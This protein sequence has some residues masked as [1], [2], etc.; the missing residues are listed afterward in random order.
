MRVVVAVLFL[1]T[2]AHAGL[3]GLLR[4]KQQAA[5]FTGIL[6]SVS[7]APFDG[8]G[9]PDVDNF[10]TAERIRSDL[11]KLA[12]QTRAV[13]LYSSTGGPEM[14][15]PI[16]NEFGLK[17]NVGAWIDKDV[18]RNEREIQAAIDLAKHN[19]NVSGIVV[20][21]ET[22]YR[23][24][25]IPLE[26]LG[27]SDEERYRLVAEENQ[28]MRDAEAQP[29]DKRDE[30]VRWATA[31][32]NVRRLTRLI[33]RVKS[34]VKAPVTSGEI[35]NIWL[36]HPE[37]AS[38]VDFIAAHILPYWEGFSAKQAVDQA[39]IIYQ[40]L[41]DAFPGKRIVIAEFGWPS[42]GY[43]R[44]A[45]VPG[46]FEQAVTLRNFVS[47]ADAVGM[48][49][50]I[51]EAIDQPWKFFEG[52]VGPYW[53]F[54][55]ASRQ[56][57]FAWTGPVVDPNYWKLAGI[58]LLV[59]I[60]LSLPILQLAA[61]TAM[62]TLL[63]SA[64]AHGAGAWAATVFAYWNGHY[65]L[66]GSAFALTLGMILLVPLVAI[67]LARV[68]EIAA[69][70]FGRK[71]RRLITR[72][73]TDAQEAKR[74]A[75]LASGEPIKAPK[76]SIH[77]P[78]YFE[79]PEM[80]KQTLDALARLDY[81]NFEVVVIINNTPDAA[82]TDP[83]R[84]HC[85][86]LGERFKFINAQKVKGFKAGALRI[87][88]ERTAADAEII[89]IIDAD[90]VV[91]PDW[92]KDLVPAFD[93][94]RVGLVQA[95]QEHRDGDR[96]L[97]HYIMNG[98][99]AGFFDIG[100]VQRNEYNGIIVHGTM[101]LIRRAAMDMAGGWSSDTICEDSDLG[102]EIM[103]HGWLTHYTNTR[104]GFG[105]LP[106]TYEAF[107]KQR[108]R[109]AYGGFQIIKKHWRRF[110][111]GNSRLSRDQRREFGVG[112]LNWLGAESLGVVVA[113]LNLIWV[114][115]VAFAD[116]AI[117]DKILTLPIIASFIVTLAHFL[118]LYRL[119]VKVGVPQMFGAM[120]A[121]MSVQ[122]TVSRAVAQGLITE[123]LAFART[124]KGG[125]TMMSVEFQAF[126]E[127]VIGVLLLIGAAI[128]VVS[129]SNIQITEIYIFA[130]VLVLQ[131]LP[132]LAAV[133]I[134]ILENS[135]IN[136]FGWW[137]AT[138]VRTAELIGLRPVALPTAIPAQQ[139]VASELHRDA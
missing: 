64:A 68:E 82:F 128:L 99:Y 13:R 43:N 90:Y 78:A 136:Q 47:R 81:P 2:A 117:P 91:T 75:A 72:A 22:V 86:E 8:S 94:P 30:A 114:P 58:A 119:R 63:L 57:K 115:I 93:D 121:A 23:G 111:P 118:V 51:V 109:W 15:P 35:W 67:A 100:M 11:K 113:I 98:E 52:G 124:S 106:D 84:D 3:W 110:M 70:A 102:L 138:A 80:L 19:A 104:Y 18:T 97:M 44:K 36:E 69:V 66:F 89:G 139:K 79:P 41:R 85:R 131:S 54:L 87:A 74:A 101:C 73:L 59:G 49:Y 103:E 61:P 134:A 1:V 65:F 26:N 42:A 71:P 45:A 12:P 40:K 38:S 122:W 96:S 56:P 37:L 34:Q 17:V 5:D 24:D 39:M 123:H 62:Q 127:A 9:H 7:Y 77:V 126:W 6:P 133:A 108:H 60:L 27:L 48:E 53:G 20:G 14:V 132:F 25:Q 112:W 107:K 76:V 129:N 83:I 120:I 130:G 92:L 32:N 105:L 29:A 116:I 135:R 28:R 31:E 4:E 21:N 10:P 46:Q 16:A 50:N 125:L 95:P 88:M 137:T 33:Q 55:D